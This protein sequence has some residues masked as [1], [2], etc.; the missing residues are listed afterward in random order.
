MIRKTL[1]KGVLLGPAALRKAAAMR[2]MRPEEAWML[3]QP[4]AVRRTYAAQVLDADG[5]L[6]LLTEVWMLRQ[7]DAV[8]ESYIEE[9]LQPELSATNAR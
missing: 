8:R 6:D 4:R 5:D 7:P 9:V 1:E 2:A 3:R